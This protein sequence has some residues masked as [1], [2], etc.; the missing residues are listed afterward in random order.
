M[1]TRK[2]LFSEWIT[3]LSVF[4]MLSGFLYSRF[5]LSTGMVILLL[6]GL[7]PANFKEN[8]KNWRNSNFA[9]Y[10]VLF[11]IIFFLSGLWSDNTEAWIKDMQVKLPFLILPCGMLGA[12]MKSQKVK[13]FILYLVL[14]ILGTG[15]L[16]S[17]FLTILDPSFFW[18]GAHIRGPVENDYLRFSLALVLGVNIVF[19]LKKERNINFFPKFF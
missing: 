18:R 15:I 4:L 17:V 5:L 3:I 13:D 10:C 16:Y 8:I 9:L 2:L 12:N 19:Y 14:G 7:N 11:F 1:K 6:N